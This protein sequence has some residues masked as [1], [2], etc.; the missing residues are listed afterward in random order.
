MLTHF[1]RRATRCEYPAIRY[2]IYLNFAA[3]IQLDGQTINTLLRYGQDELYNK[4]HWP[5]KLLLLEI[6][7]RAQAPYLP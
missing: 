6:S 5:D 4:L 7:N 2:I 3:V 1:K